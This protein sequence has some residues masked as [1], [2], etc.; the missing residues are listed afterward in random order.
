MNDKEIITLVKK[1]RDVGLCTDTSKNLW[2]VLHDAKLY[3]P[4]YT[5]WNAQLNK[6]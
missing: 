4:I 6:R 5:N 2:K 3:K 1:Y